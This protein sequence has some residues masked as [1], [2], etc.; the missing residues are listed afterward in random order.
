MATYCAITQAEMEEVLSESKG[1]TRKVQSGSNE[2]VYS[3][4]LKSVPGA[5]VL[6]YSSITAAGAR[7]SG[8]D[9]IRVCAVRGD[10]GYIKSQRVHRVQGWRANL[11][12]RVMSVIAEAKGR[13]QKEQERA[14]VQAVNPL[15]ERANAWLRAYTGNFE[16]LSRMRELVVQGRAL[17]D[18]QRDAVLRCADR[19]EARQARQAARSTPAPVRDTDTRFGRTGQLVAVQVQGDPWA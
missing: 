6:V 4:T 18:G 10:R 16:F 17:S 19:E 15:N 1:W 11:Q 7:S 9:A 14:Q 2:F 13:A 8:H 12:T 3:F 5:V